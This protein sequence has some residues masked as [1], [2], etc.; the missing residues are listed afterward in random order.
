MDGK[1][2]LARGGKPVECYIY[3][4]NHYT[5][6]S[7]GSGNNSYDIKDQNNGNSA[8]VKKEQEKASMNMKIGKPWDDNVYYSGSL[9]CQRA[10]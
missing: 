9:L 7:P 4:N 8:P 2:I 3:S 6:K 10:V 5:N 1:V